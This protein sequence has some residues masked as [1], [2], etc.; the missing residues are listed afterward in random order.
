[1]AFAGGLELD[2]SVMVGEQ[3]FEPNRSSEG[4]CGG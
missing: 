3:K 2:L 4:Q 1:M